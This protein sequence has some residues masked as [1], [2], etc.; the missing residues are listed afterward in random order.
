M[1]DRW[2]YTAGIMLSLL[3][4][5]GLTRAGSPSGPFATSPR[6]DTLYIT[7]SNWFDSCHQARPVCAEEGLCVYIPLNNV[8]YSQGQ[9]CKWDS[10]Y[11]SRP[12]TCCID[13]L[14]ICNEY[15]A[16]P[17]WYFFKIAETGSLVIS[18][19]NTP[20]VA[21]NWVMWG[22]F[23]TPHGACMEG[24]IGTS[25]LIGGGYTTYNNQS[26]TAI[27]NIPNA[28]QGK[29]YLLDVG[30]GGRATFMHIVQANASQPGA[31]VLDCD[32]ITHCN[33]FQ[34][35][36]SPSPCNPLTNTFTL[37][38]EAYFSNS[39]STGYLVVWDSATGYSS[40]YI[41]PFIS[42]FNYTIPGLP[43]D[44]QIHRIYASF[45][46]SVGCDASVTF[47]APVLCPDAAISGGGPLCD[48]G[49]DSAMI[50]ISFTPNIQWPVTF[51]W[52]VN[53]VPQAPI[54]WPGPSPY[55]FYTRQAGL[56][57]LDTSY[58]A[59]CAGSVS[60]QASVILN[61]LPPIQ[62]GPDIHVCQGRP[63]VLDAGPGFNKYIWS[64]DETTQSI[65][66]SLSGTYWVMVQGTN[67][68]FNS[69][70]VSVNFVPA[71]GPLLIKHQ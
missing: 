24:L 23:D 63:V 42:P 19:W 8:I 12:I 25:H 54:S 59:V 69:D 40:F 45:W 1:K 39:P 51:A 70:T 4:L 27:I 20:S 33:I 43:C 37:S 50:A 7:D 13:Y 34:L 56:Y 52:R 62:L 66:V 21:F 60:G 6:D 9:C 65:T 2:Y 29:F 14:S 61:P 3:G 67:G 64:T 17:H 58:N 35:T 46:D 55:V 71:P 30:K 48:N 53:G 36:T 26:D 49:I 41:P 31:A 28:E 11:I 68:C 22:P 16:N 10:I 5:L 38:G 47:Q 15:P 32:I 57:T 18:I 44:N